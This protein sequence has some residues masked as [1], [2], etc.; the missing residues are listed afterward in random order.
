[1]NS[2]LPKSLIV[3]CFVFIAHLA[4]SQEKSK[5]ELLHANSIKSDKNIK[6]GARRLIGN[7]KFKQDSTIM[8][9]DSAYFFSEKNMFEAYSNVHL[10]KQGDNNID[11]K[12]EF[13]RHNG[14]L[15]MAYFR[16][17]VVLRDT[18]VVLYTDSLDYD[19]KQDIGYYL[20]GGTIVDSA[21]TLT[22]K[23]GHYFQHRNTIYFKD[24]VVVHHNNGEFEMYTDTLKYNTLSETS[25][26]L[27]PTE[28]YN[29]TNYMYA[30]FGWYNTV[31][32]TSMFKK[33]ALYT[34]PKQSIEADSIYYDRQAEHGIA[35]SNVIAVDTAEQVT[36]K[37]NYL[38]LFQKTEQI[39]VTDSALLIAILEG[40]SLFLHADTLFSAYDTSG[41]HRTF[42]AYHHTK[43][44]KSNFQVKTDSLFF[45]MEDSIVEFHGSPILWAEQNQITAE[46]IEGFVKNDKLDHFKLYNGGLIISEEDTVHYNQIK[47]K[48]M[49][50]YLKN[51]QLSKIDVFKKSETIYFPVN[52]DGIIGINKST[53]SD[54]TLMFKQN[55]IDRIVYRTKYVGQMLP[56][57]DASPADMKVREFNWFDY[58]RPKSSMD[59]FL[60]QQIIENKGSSKTNR[61]GSLKNTK[62]PKARK[63]LD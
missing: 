28:F 36:I 55:K 23:K 51:N 38:E 6:Q 44:F 3:F 30:E 62:P 13:L 63:E 48:E 2:F 40:D 37:G 15:K 50:G 49:I 47:G 34:N 54:I 45:S 9:C 52:E 58:L 14:N 41:I 57:D 33:N 18:Q 7:V 39:L 26:F 56:I 43:I 8:E 10:Y 32:N 61:T 25:F 59:V 1:M 21:T 31:I 20:Y 11:V 19:I 35:Y 4:F 22:S 12:S 29:D 53:S 17:D 60:W 16:N 24:N 27:G 46:Y 42:K 5:V